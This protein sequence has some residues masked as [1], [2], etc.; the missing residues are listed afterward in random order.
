MSSLVAREL[1][2][3]YGAADEPAISDVNITVRQG[4]F[5]TVIGPSGCGKSTLLHALGGMLSPH[6]GTVEL[7]GNVVTTP[8]PRNAAFVFQDYS[9]FPWKTVLDN[10]AMGLRFAGVPKK[11]ALE[12]AR[13]ELQFV[14]LAAT[15][16]KYPTE[17]SGGMQQRVSVARALTLKP[18]FLLLDEPFGALDEQT[19]RS[20]G[21][22]LTRILHDS[23]Q[24]V[25]LITHSLE[26]A[27]FWGDRII[28]M[29]AGPGRVVKEIAVTAPWPRD[30]VF[31]TTPEFAELRAELF[32]LIQPHA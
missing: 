11:E 27:I 19:R 10:V 32:H 22:D 13:E 16:D 18:K 30:L 12:V 28:V 17:L 2:V 3:V 21:Q 24:S 14:G 26:E 6:S 29:Q 1:E 8:D 23:G 9:L 15:A 31:M 5:V 7:A 20:L 4:E 25:V